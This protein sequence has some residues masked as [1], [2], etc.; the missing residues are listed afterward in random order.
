MSQVPGQ[1]EHA[2]KLRGG[3]Y[4]TYQRIFV[5]FPDVWSYLTD[6]P[7]GH[8][9]RIINDL[10]GIVHSL[11]DFTCPILPGSGDYRIELLRC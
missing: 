3:D 2:E 6:G 7:Q 4:Y 9:V 5:W 8:L 1:Y 11:K 10:Q